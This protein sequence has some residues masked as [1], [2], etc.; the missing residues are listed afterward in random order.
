[1]KLQSV[2]AYAPASIS[3]LGPAFDVL[4]IAIHRPGDIVIAQRQRERGLSFSVRSQHF[5]VPSDP[6]E[7]VAAYV[8][9]LILNEAKFPFGIKLVLNKNMPVG[10]GLGS[11]AASSAAAAVAVNALLPKPLKKYDLL[12]FII[13]GERKACGSPH[14]DNATPSLLGGAW[15]I[16]SYNPLDVI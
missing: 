5:N 11:S 13:E 8:A 7:N 12:Q 4:G 16:R 9:N 3:N 14:A 10:S 15:L 2:K 1:M 6:K